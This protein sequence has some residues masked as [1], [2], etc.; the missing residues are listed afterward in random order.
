MARMSKYNLLKLSYI[1]IELIKYVKKCFLKYSCSCSHNL[2]LFFFQFRFYLL[3]FII[4]LF[5]CVCVVPQSIQEFNI[6]MSQ[7]D[8]YKNDSY[9][10]WLLHKIESFKFSILLLL[11]IILLFKL[12][13]PL[14]FYVKH[15]I[16]I[17]VTA[18][19]SIVIIP[20]ILFNPR[21]TKNIE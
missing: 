6:K 8:G 5:V 20:L 15:T 16:F 10:L 18:I 1:Y 21:S 13:S 17:I 7:V 2:S 9:V 12:K 19:Y 14:Q 4:I 3:S 11:I